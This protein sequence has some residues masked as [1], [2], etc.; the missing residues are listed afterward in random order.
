MEG[1][2]VPAFSKRPTPRVRKRSGHNLC[3]PMGSVGPAESRCGGACPP[4][5]ERAGCGSTRYGLPDR[6]VRRT[7]MT[8]LPLA[9]PL[10]PLYNRR[11]LRCPSAF[12]RRVKRE[13]GASSDKAGTAPATVGEKGHSRCHCAIGVGRRMFRQGCRSRVRIPAWVS[14]R[15]GT[16]EGGVRDNGVPP[17]PAVSPSACLLLSFNCVRGVRWRS[18]KCTNRVGGWCPCCC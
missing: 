13:A 17:L 3:T 2:S 12:R 16:A 8:G 10:E 1:G 18:R 4:C 6:S 14:V 5:R 9:F 7:S 15:F 11:S